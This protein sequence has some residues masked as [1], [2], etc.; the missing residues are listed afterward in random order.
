M[1][2]L[3]VPASFQDVDEAL[4]IGIGVGM[5]VLQ[6]VP[7]AGL[8]CEMDHAGKAMLLKQRLDTGTISQ[9]EL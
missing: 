9:V 5:R 4:E 1:P 6:R 7:Y 2:T 8:S 3:G